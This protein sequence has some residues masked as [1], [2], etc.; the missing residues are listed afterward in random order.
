MHDMLS[1]MADA[2]STPNASSNNQIVYKLVLT[3]TLKKLEGCFD[4]FSLHD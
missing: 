4:I 1:P 2:L 3:L